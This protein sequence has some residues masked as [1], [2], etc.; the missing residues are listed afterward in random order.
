MPQSG[1]S[2]GSSPKDF[3]FHFL[4]EDMKTDDLQTVQMM[5]SPE[6]QIIT[7]KVN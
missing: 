3:F 2:S 1:L 7:S 5:F 6:V 4:L